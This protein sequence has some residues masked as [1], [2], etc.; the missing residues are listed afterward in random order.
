MSV[1]IT[2]LTMDGFESLPVHGRRCVFWEMEPNVIPD[3]LGGEPFESEF[4]KEV[5]VSM[6]LLEW[7]T[8]GQMAVSRKTGKV[9]G[10]AF[11]GPPRSVPRSALFPTSPVSADAVILSSMWVDPGHDNAAE[12]LARAVIVDLTRRGVRAIEAFGIVRS[13]RADLDSEQGTGEIQGDETICPRCMIDAEFLKESGF[14]VVSAHHR[15][16]RL[17][18]ELD[19][20]L[21]WKAGVESALEKLVVMAAIDVAGRERTAV[22]V[23]RRTTI[24]P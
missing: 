23:G 22:T 20:D 2:P 16:P 7:G 18:L 6:I 15:F 14:D 13:E 12:D 17:R 19:E 9:V 10:A 24:M 1:T 4:D 3:T 8:C 11:Y 21:G 5:W